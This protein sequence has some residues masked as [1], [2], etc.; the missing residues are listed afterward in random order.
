MTTPAPIT[1]AEISVAGVR[2]IVR[3][4]GPTAAREAVLFVHGNP[5]SGEDWVD[6]LGRVGGFA[7]ALAPDMPG[8]GKA[9]RS[10]DF[11]YTVPGYARYLGGVVEQL[12]LERVHLVLHDFGGPWGLAW[13]SDHARMLASLTLIN[14]GAMPGYRWHR[15][16]RIWRTPVLGELF[17]AAMTRWTGRTLL[18]LENPKPFPRQI[19]DRLFDQTDRGTKRAMLRLYRAT[20]DLGA[21]TVDLAKR[22]ST[23]RVPLLVLWGAADTFLPVRYAEEQRRFFD[24]VDIHVL[25]GCGHWPFFDD[26]EGV[27]ALLL[28]F[29]RGRLG[30]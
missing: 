27:S 8:Y 19:A 17:L 5:G 26:P 22:L 15:Y 28:P 14:I 23:W 4:C 20:P 3:A 1:L 10:R 11:D 29:L 2:T 16:A 21:L 24:P 12:G 9:D 6:L 25:P 18:N 30:R 13:A 7:R